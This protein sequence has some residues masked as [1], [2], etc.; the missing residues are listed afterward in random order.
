MSSS[1]RFLAH[2]VFRDQVEN[3]DRAHRD[4]RK[5]LR[6]QFEKAAADPFNAGEAMRD[7]PTADLQ[8]RILKTWVK[9]RGGY[10]FLYIALPERRVVMGLF[11][12]SV[13]RSELDYSKFPWESWA[14]QIYKDLLGGNL[15]AF[16]EW[17][18]EEK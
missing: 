14:D 5:A 9:G 17:T 12:S 10:R 13:R 16:E 11:V 18:F 6:K 3:F 2:R 7:V 15:D 1:F 4:A 8:G